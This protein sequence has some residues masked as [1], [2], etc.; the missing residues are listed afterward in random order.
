MNLSKLQEVVEDREAWH[1]TVQWVAQS[2]TQLSDWT[3]FYFRKWILDNF[4]GKGMY[5]ILS[6]NIYEIQD[7]WILSSSLFKSS[8]QL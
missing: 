8:N 7:T 1:A 2:W 5:I 6:H 4:S 3:I